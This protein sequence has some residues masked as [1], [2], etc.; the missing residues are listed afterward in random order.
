MS[1]LFYRYIRPIRF[2]ETR[3]EFN[4]QPKGGICLR[5]EETP[6]G[7]LWFTFSRCHPEDLFNRAVA[8]KLADERAINLKSDPSALAAIGAIP[9]NEQ[10][11][12]LAWGVV[13]H[14]R[15]W[16]WSSSISPLVSHYMAIEWL[17][18]ADALEDLLMA[19]ER[20]KEKGRVWITAAH[21]MDSAASY[22]RL[23]AL[24]S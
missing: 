13:Q 23:Q 22:S 7:W 24:L 12:I 16:K 6:E 9:H 10:A 5:F 15:S 19:N 17:G 11:D 14:C 21:A 4:T 18:F 3:L 2:D 1:S 20:E 8:K